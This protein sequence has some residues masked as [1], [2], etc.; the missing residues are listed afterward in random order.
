MS[1][2]FP[3]YNNSLYSLGCGVAS[4]LGVKTQCRSKFDLSGNKLVLLL[5]DGFGWNIMERSLGEVK[6]A[7]KI[8]GIFPSTT[9]TTL[10]TIFTARTPAEHGVL[11]YN[12]YV[13][14]LGSI[15]NTLR[16]THPTSNER[17][18]LANGIPFEKVFPNAK[19]YLHEVKEGTASLLPSGID[20]TEFTRVVH[21]PT[22]ETRTY[23]NV[24]DA[25]ESLKDLMGKGIRFIYAYIPDIDSLAHKYGP[26]S[27]PVILATREIFMR[28]FS[29]FKERPDYTAVITADHG[30]IDTSQTIEIEKDQD[31]MSMLELPPYGD[32]RALFLRSRYDL[33]VY[34]QGKYNLK[35]FTKEEVLSLLGGAEKIVDGI[36]D[37]VGVPLDYASYFFSFREKS[38]YARLKGHHGGLLREELEV[39]LV[40]VNG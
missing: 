1:I 23:L 31:L 25:Y 40:I 37:F 13:K 32:S 21:G 19:G 8:H 2:I 38:N 7:T 10:T 36:P 3:N 15:I 26:Y 27:E 14:N 18:S 9:S 30:L 12:T 20:N 22:Q 29:L 39:P 17:D 4:W 28:F 5:L 35:V 24:W 6:E 11:G 33:K 16:Y 34:L